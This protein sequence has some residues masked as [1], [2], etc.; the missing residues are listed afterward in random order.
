MP[1]ALTMKLLGGLAGLLILVGLVLG[2]K[3]YKSLAESRGQSLA[4]ICQATRDASGQKKLPCADVPAQVKFM[5]E[6]VKTLSGSLA[7]QSAAVAAMGDQTKA[8]Q[9][10]TAQASQKAQERA[11]KAEATASR[12]TAS[13]RA[14]EAQA[15]PCAPSKAL[16]D[17]WK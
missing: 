9:A 14:G 5:G 1:S 7:R 10:A 17:S 4:T 15:K 16:T 3:H 6:A 8:Q 11:G 13:S 2:L 12:L